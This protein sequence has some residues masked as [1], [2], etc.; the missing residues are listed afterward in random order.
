ML[1]SPLN[2]ILYVPLHTFLQTRVYLHWL[3]LSGLFPVLLKF[4]V[5][6]LLTAISYL[7]RG[8]IWSLASSMRQ[9]YE[10]IGIGAE[11]AEHSEEPTVHTPSW[12]QIHTS[13]WRFGI[14]SCAVSTSC[15]FLVN[16]TILIWSVSTYGVGE[17]GR[18]VL[19]DGNCETVRKLNLVIHLFINC[20]S[21]VLLSC[22]NYC[23]QCLSAATRS[24]IDKVHQRSNGGWLDIGVPSIRNLREIDRK[25]ALLWLLLGTSSLPLHL[26]YV[27]MFFALCTCMLI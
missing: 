1:P 23:M 22:S 20:F 19:Y 16:F 13:G 6:S 9:A 5:A 17:G 3:Q 4:F 11:S 27:S 14:I 26:L 18:Q 7:V 10:L 2:L 21:T 15:V 25:R 12:R 24:D 8:S